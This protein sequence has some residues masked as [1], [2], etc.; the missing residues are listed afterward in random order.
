MDTGQEM[1][2]SGMYM[3]V[4]FETDDTVNMDGFK[5]SY[6]AVMGDLYSGQMQDEKSTIKPKSGIY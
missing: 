1:V 5:I 3:F 6:R 4:Y 2:S